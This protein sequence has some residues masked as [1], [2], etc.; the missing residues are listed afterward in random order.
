MR[1]LLRG[2]LRGAIFFTTARRVHQ[3]ALK[4]DLLC[5][6]SSAITIGNLVPRDLASAFFPKLQNINRRVAACRRAVGHMEIFP[7]CP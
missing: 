6:V 7:A 3:L 5:V 2:L 4:S 1:S